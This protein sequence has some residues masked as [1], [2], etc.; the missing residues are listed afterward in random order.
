L[1]AAVAFVASPVIASPPP[2]ANN[3]WGDITSVVAGPGL[4]G[5]ATEGDATLAVVFGGNGT[6][7]TAARSD[8]NHD[9]RYL[10]L[11]GG[12]LSGSLTAPQFVSSA[13]QGTAEYP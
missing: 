8:H 5:G 7:N 11:I 9:D 4:T 3:A 13:A 1:S 12:T 2:Q 10:R 6:A